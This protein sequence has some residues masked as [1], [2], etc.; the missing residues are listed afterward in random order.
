MS[1]T[2]VWQ[3]TRRQGVPMT[4]G[5]PPGTRKPPGSRPT[6]LALNLFWAVFGS[7]AVAGPPPAAGLCAPDPPDFFFILGLPRPP[8]TDLW[9]TWNGGGPVRDDRPQDDLS[10]LARPS[11]LL[12]DRPGSWAQP[13]LIVD[14][15]CW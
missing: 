5:R 7:L 1:W 6:R 10:F 11:F 9:G 2:A 13:G 4:N 8:T 15:G 12:G 3:K 14:P